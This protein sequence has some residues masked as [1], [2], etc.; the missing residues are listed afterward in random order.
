[1][2]RVTRPGSTLLLLVL[3]LPDGCSD[4]DRRGGDGRAGLD[5]R[6]AEGGHEAGAVERALGDAG[7]CAA[8]PGVSY[9][10]LAPSNPYSGDPSKQADMN[11]LTRSWRA[12]SDTKGLVD[13]SGPTD[14][15]PGPQLYSLF[16]DDRVPTFSA[17]YQLQ[18]WDWPKN[19]PGPFIVDP[20]VTLA[21]MAT[22]AGEE[23]RT[24]FSGYDLGGGHTAMV[25]YAAKG[26]ITLKYT[27]D[28]DVAKGYTVH[29]DG[30]CVE[31][32]LQALYDQ[33]NAS[34]R[35]QLP[36][37]KSRQPIGRALGTE[38]RAA[39]RDTGSLMDPRSRKDWWQGK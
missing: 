2:D 22:T 8:I 9:E 31:P 16:A 20:A 14:T 23:L 11:L 10:T 12:A 36:V 4:F 33:G 28:D 32:S 39:V 27:P 7:T 21:G 29:L 19:A 18:D 37:L 1:M 17:V 35:A 26:T 34:K 38:V 30:I 24:P 6:V 15:K 5:G 3:L 13:L 25:I